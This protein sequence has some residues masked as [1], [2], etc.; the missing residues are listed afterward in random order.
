MRF[1][2]I[3][4]LFSIITFSQNKPLEVKINSIT[5]KDLKPNIRKYTIDY[6]IE[7]L[8]NQEISFF[9]T[10]NTLIANA[11]SSMTLFPVYKIYINSEFTP[12]DGPFFEK[13]GIDWEAFR[14]T[15]KNLTTTEFKELAQKTYDAFQN[16]NKAIIENYKKGGGKIYDD[17]W[18]LQNDNLMKSKITLKPNEIRLFEIQTNWDKDRYFKQDDLEYYLDEKD[19]YEFEL[20]L[21]LKKTAFQNQLSEEEFSAIEKDKSFIQGIFTS[22]KI[23]I[24]FK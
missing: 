24:D 6:Q 5:F 17:H 7:N 11:A 2:Y 14:E 10:P 18:I 22:N 23:L 8:T 1:T 21:D 16:T 3:L 15:N 4:L 12:L 13:Y 20:I 19:N 9:L